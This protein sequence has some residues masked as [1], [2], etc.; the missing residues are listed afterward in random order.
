MNF[1][2]AKRFLL[3]LGSGPRSI[4]PMLTLKWLAG[5][6]QNYLPDT[7]PDVKTLQPS[8]IEHPLRLRTKSSDFFVFRQIMIEQ[9]YQPLANLPIETVLDLGANIGMA[10]AWFL[11]QFPKARIFAVEAA[12]DNYEACC[13]NL[14]PYGDRAR[15]LHAAAWSTCATLNLRQRNTNADNWVSEQGGS[16]QE[17]TEVQGWDIPSLI[18]MSGFPQID[19]L[20]IDIE[21]AEAPIFSAGV[22][23]WM[24]KVRNLCIELHGEACRKAFMEAL[25]DYEF[26]LGKSGE[27]DLCTNLRARSAAQAG[28]LPA[29][30][31]S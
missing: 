27:L 18:A 9:E 12:Q 2:H 13:R 6:T 15:V 5:V 29:A 31:R 10:S 19:L 4:G 14:A 1:T 3:V 28:E 20:K 30:Q 22:S 7:P 26:E 16:G 24:G 17:T 25:A 21:G 23:A 11:S 8:F